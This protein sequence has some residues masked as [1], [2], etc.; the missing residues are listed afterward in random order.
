MFVYLVSSS[1]L[2][3]LVFSYVAV[4]TFICLI[5][6]SVKKQKK[7]RQLITTSLLLLPLLPYAIVAAQTA[8]FL[9]TMRRP[10]L[11]VLLDAGISDGNISALRV[12]TITPRQSVVEV[13]EPCTGGMNIDF[14]GRPLTGEA[15]ETVTLVRRGLVWRVKDYDTVWSNCGS[16]DGNTFPP[17]P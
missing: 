11:Q 3:Y 9:P 16:A 4:G 17:Y 2:A 1:I 10:V 6:A 5:R 7:A 15:A 13:I 12:L 14:K 8:L